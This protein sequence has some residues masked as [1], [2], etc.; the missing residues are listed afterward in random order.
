LSFIYPVYNHNW[1]NISIIYIYN[2]TSIKRIILT[3]NKINREVGRAKDL[4]ASWYLASIYTDIAVL[5]AEVL[6][7]ITPQYN[8]MFQSIM[9]I[10]REI[11]N[12]GLP[13]LA[14]SPDDNLERSKHVV[15]AII[16]IGLSAPS[17]CLCYCTVYLY[18]LCYVIYKNNGMQ[19]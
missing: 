19:Y 2:K 6:H 18:D 8:H 15:S 11:K 1:R 17:D 5:S 7:C 14:H 16:Q 9:V 3:T 10:F 12:N 13:V 4:S